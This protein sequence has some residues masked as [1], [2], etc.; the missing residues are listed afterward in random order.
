MTACVHLQVPPVNFSSD[1]VEGW[2][3]KIYEYHEQNDFSG[4]GA[5]CLL[6][7]LELQLSFCPKQRRGNQ[8]EKYRYL[9]E[10]ESLHSGRITLSA[11]VRG[12][13]ALFVPVE[14][15]YHLSFLEHFSVP[16]GMF[17]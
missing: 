5:A 1:A 9:K 6:K 3:S 7:S 13:L 12:I 2:N 17:L 8:E 14:G 11:R 16:E 4:Q 15:R 10:Q